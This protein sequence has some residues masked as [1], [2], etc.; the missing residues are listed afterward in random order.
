MNTKRYLDKDKDTIC[1][2]ITAP[3]QAGISVLRVCGPAS[4]N[5]I[6]NI[7]SFLPRDLESHRVYYGLAQASPEGPAIDEVLVSYFK[8]GRSFTGEQTFEISCH[9]N[10]VIVSEI[11][12]SL[13]AFGARVAERGEFTYRAFMNG[14]IDLVQ[15]ESVLE[16]IQ[17][18][19]KRAAQTALRQLQGGFSSRLRELLGEL[20]WIL[21]NL[22]A[23]IDFSAEDIEIATNAELTTRTR[24]LLETVQELLA[25]QEKGRILKTGFQ[26][27][28]AGRPNAGKSSLLNALLEEERAIVTDVPGTTRDMVEGEISIDGI[29]V[30]LVDTAGWRETDDRVERIGVERSLERVQNVDRILYIVDGEVGWSEKDALN[31]ERLPK[32][33]TVLVWNKSDVAAPRL[34]ESLNSISVSARTGFGLPELRGYLREQIAAEYVEDAPALWN[35]RHF[36]GLANLRRSLESTLGQLETNGSPDLVALELQLGLQSV[37]EMLGIVFDDQV[38]DRVFREFCIGK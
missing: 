5:I 34:P 37:H 22:E 28:L 21:A 25:Q 26:V 27:A 7:C 20:T 24:S 15:A 17:S 13:C 12:A 31:W 3:G 1:A 33:R 36:E 16:L 9:G 11:L 32:N 6:R 18:R 8:S 14:R 29:G 10:Q 30:T 38:M 23:N 19:S 4:E 35:A 2:S